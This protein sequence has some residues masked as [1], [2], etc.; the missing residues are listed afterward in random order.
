MNSKRIAPFIFLTALIFFA[1][2]PSIQAQSWLEKGKELL[3]QA[4]SQ[5][6]DKDLSS[7]T[8]GKGLKEALKVGTANVVDE[9]GQPGGFFNDSEL[10]IPPPA[11]L[12]KVQS[13]LK[14]VGASSMLDD[15]EHK[16]NQAAERATPKAKDLFWQAISRM[17]I[18]DVSSIYNGPDDAA[19]RYFEREM[20]APLAAEMKP[21]VQETLSQVGAVQSYSQIMDRYN[22]IPL[23]PEVKADLTTYTLDKT[24]EGIFTRLAQEEASIR[25]DPAK[26]STELLQTVFGP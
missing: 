5:S 22:A 12:D 17:T 8:V 21:T 16:L 20:S 13:V 4:T 18:Q 26:R 9:L 19:T 7:D 3:Q 6:Q 1:S 23:V 25:N 15:L 24:L 2:I 11:S 10:H 14:R